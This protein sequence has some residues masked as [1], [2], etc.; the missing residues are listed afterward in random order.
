MIR[1]IKL[2]GDQVGSL[3]VYTTHLWLGLYNLFKG[4]FCYSFLRF[5]HF[6]GINFLFW[7]EPF[8]SAL[9]FLFGKYFD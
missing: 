8:F 1:G 4:Y 2:V 9:Y 6:Q 3:I 7:V 5:L